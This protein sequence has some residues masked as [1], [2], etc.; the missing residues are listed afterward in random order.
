[1]LAGRLLFA[2]ADAPL[3]DGQINAFH[4]HDALQFAQ[5]RLDLASNAAARE[6]DSGISS[7]RLVDEGGKGFFI[8]TGLQRRGCIQL[9]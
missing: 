6:H 4:G 7:G 1:M 8:P 3:D 2:I 5:W 9:A